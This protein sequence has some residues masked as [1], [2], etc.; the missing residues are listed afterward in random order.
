MRARTTWNTPESVPRSAATNRQADPYAMNQE[1]QQPP[2]DKYL[3]GDPSAF[4]ED[5]TTPNNWE[6]EYQ[7]GVTN[8]DEIGLAVPRPDTF[9]HPEKT[10]NV[11]HILKKADLS[12]KISRRMLGANAPEAV[13]EQQAA[14][15]M[16]LPDVEVI[17]TYNRLAGEMPPQFKDNAEKKQEEAK[18][19]ESQA[20]E[21]VKQAALRGDN[22]ALNIALAKWASIRQAN[23]PQQQAPAQQQ[24]QAG[25]Q[26]GQP[27]QGTQNQQS[28]WYDSNG[29]RPGH[30]G[31][32]NGPYA[33][34]QQAPAQQQQ[35]AQGQPQQQAPAQQ[36]QAQGQPQQAP[37][38]MQQQGFGTEQSPNIEAQV[39]QMIQETAAAQQVQANQQQAPAQQQQ[40]AGQQAQAQGQPQQ[41]APAQQQAGQQQQAQGQPQQQA[42]AQQQACGPMQQQAQGQPQQQAVVQASDD[43]LLDQML[44]PGAGQG[45]VSPAIAEMDIE[46]QAPSMDIGDVPFA[47]GED[48]MLQQ[49]F[50]SDETMAAQQAQQ[51]Q[52]QGQQTQAN[53]RTAGLRT[54]G[55]RPSF[56]V[57]RIGGAGS[58]PG[59]GQEVEKLTSLWQ[60]A[61]DVREAF[62]LKTT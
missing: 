56:G 1:H 61:P 27:Q 39:Q 16:L 46:M 50:A 24:Q 47:P 3:T 54:V 28:A 12:V 41:Q 53:V 13:L 59:R 11:N 29:G 23:D 58:A 57:T 20:Q 10:A 30:S 4:A 19:A 37:A 55:T 9:D 33:G 18:A 32:D 60:S 45:G 8:R 26:Q 49:L 62:G 48:V 15:I 42:P 34:Q 7:G 52:G 6:V 2:S 38:P 17:N 14:A 44:A 21:E 31:P 40:Q 22:A 43:Q 51:A 25:Q 36:Q 5:I 35:Q